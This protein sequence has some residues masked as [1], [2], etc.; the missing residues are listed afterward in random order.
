MKFLQKKYMRQKIHLTYFLIQQIALSKK[1]KI[2]III[3]QKLINNYQRQRVINYSYHYI[4]SS[5]R[6]NISLIHFINEKNGTFKG[7]AIYSY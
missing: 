7:S 1:K 3:C 6:L 4:F 2:I 5:Y